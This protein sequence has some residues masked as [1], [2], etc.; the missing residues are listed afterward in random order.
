MNKAIILTNGRLRTNDAKTAHGLIRGTERFDIVAVIDPPTAG[1]DAGVVLDGKHRNIPVYD[2]LENAIGHLKTVDYLIV[3]IAT[4]GGVLPPDMLEIIKTA[5]KNRISIVNGLHEYLN[6]KPEITALAE[7]YGAQLIDVRKPKSRKDLHFWTG[8]IYQ[9]KAPIIAVIGMDC[10]LGKRTTARMIREACEAAGINA[11]MIYTGQ[12]GWLQ[13]GKYGFIFDSTLNDFVS[14]EI[15]HAIVSCWKE[16][17]ADLILVEGQSALRNPSGPCGSEFLISG[18]AK[19]VVLVHAPKR[20]YYDDDPLWGEIPSVESE[21][22]IIEKFGSKVIALALN[23]EGCLHDEATEYQ[24]HYEDR[25]KIPVLL[26]L[27]E[28]VHKI[29]PTLKALKP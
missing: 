27:E 13:G 24:R 6:E 26:P 14:G 7:E 18:N 12:T 21:L 20:K 2:S 22:E 16:T 10:A 9:V 23:T 29:I 3:G 15:E 4:V 5:I 19:Y 25:L 28:G 17:Q 1:Q 8:E 11:Q